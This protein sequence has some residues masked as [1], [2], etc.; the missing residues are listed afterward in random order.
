MIYSKHHFINNEGLVEVG[1]LLR[2]GVTDASPTDTF[3]I[4]IQNSPSQT[5]VDMGSA[6]LI[7]TNGILPYAWKTISYCKMYSPI[8]SQYAHSQ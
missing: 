3:T 1:S 6:M 5:T 2:A 7:Q 4:W 8:Q